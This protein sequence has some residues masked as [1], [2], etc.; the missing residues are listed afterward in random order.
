MLKVSLDLQEFRWY[1]Q[2]RLCLHRIESH[3]SRSGAR[4]CICTRKTV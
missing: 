2:H 1:Q 3:S 4:L